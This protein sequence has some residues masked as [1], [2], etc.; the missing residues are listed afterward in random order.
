VLR[1]PDS[2]PGEAVDIRRLNLL[3]TVTSQLRIAEIIGKDVDDVRR[4]FSD[5]GYTE[6]DEKKDQLEQNK[7]GNPLAQ[8]FN[9]R[10]T[11]DTSR[12]AL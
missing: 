7:H 8:I 4:G 12:E 5:L 6:T 10:A 9:H 2:L 3:L 1:K 11:E